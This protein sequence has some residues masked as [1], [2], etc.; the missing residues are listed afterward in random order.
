[1]P[2]PEFEPCTPAFIRFL[3]EHYATNDLIVYEGLRLSYTEAATNS[4]RLARGML[5]SGISKGSRVGLLMPNSPDFVVAW[6]AAARIG[7]IIIPINTFYKPKE[8]A[9]ILHHADI[10]ILLTADKLLNNDYLERLETCI[11]ALSEEPPGSIGAPLL[12]QDF[13]FLRQVYVWGESSRQWTLPSQQLLDAAASVSQGYLDAVEHCVHPADPLTVIYSSGSTADPKGAIHTHGSVIRH[14]YNLNHWRDLQSDDRIFSP[15]P[16]FWVGG[17]IFTL[18]CALHKGCT[19][20]C[21]EV[22]EP[23]KTLLLL[24]SERA[25]LVTGWPHYG[26]ALVDHP[27][28]GE[29][30]LSAIR[31][32]N[33]YALL[34]DNIRPA[35]PQLRSNALGMTETCGP[36]SIDHMD[37]DLP[38]TMR[39]SFGRPLEGVEHKVVDPDT[40]EHLATGTEGEICIRGYNVM[41]G[42]YKVERE[43]S[44]DADGFYRS[45]DSG[46]LNEDGFLF[47]TARLGELIKTAGANVT[48]LE[49]EITIDEQPEIQCSYVVGLPHPDRGQ[50]VAGAIVLNAGQSL[51]AG[52]LRKRLK[53]ELASYKVPSKIFFCTRDEIPFTDSGKVDKRRLTDYLSGLATQ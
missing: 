35:D 13:P 39:G 32:G 46:H 52:E 48:P 30:D 45:G 21:E 43:D 41:Q 53:Q 14:S 49:V 27:S 40:G 6:L 2:F 50:E 47:F 22:F 12:L 10:Q 42:L 31:G 37:V 29:R 4:A 20:I 51:D 25:T 9:F 24:E 1:M 11:P 17:L 15:M 8:L 23:G 38:E 16:F 19:L 26:S 7:A 36:H 28:C 5:A 44:F 33:I 3:E 18:H 34:P